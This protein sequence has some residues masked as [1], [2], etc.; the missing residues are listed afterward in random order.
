MLDFVKTAFRGFFSVFLWIIFI[1]CTLGGLVG[2]SSFGGIGVPL[3]LFLG[4]AAGGLIVVVYGGLIATFLDMS[5]KLDGIDEKSKNMDKLKDMEELLRILIISIRE[6]KKKDTDQVASYFIDSRDGQKYRVVNIGGRIWMAQNLN[7]Q[8]QTGNSWC[9]GNNNSNGNKYGRLYDWETAKSVPPA[10]WHLPTR[11]DWDELIEAVG[12]NM[13]GKALKSITD[14]YNGGGGMD[15]YEFSALPGG[16]RSSD[17]K[18]FNVNGHGCWWTS[19]EK[20][21][22]FAY[23][24]HMVYSHDNVDDSIDRKDYGFSVRCVKDV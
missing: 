24:K 10:G 17:D 3:G 14:W 15:I 6:S 12:G 16:S 7:Y 11:Q 4:A 13:A 18:Y 1:G 8:P 21:D 19:T 20:D 23:R 5:A 2:G 9:Y 22:K